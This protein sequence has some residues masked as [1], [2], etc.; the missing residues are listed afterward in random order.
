[1]QCL[2]FRLAGDE[3]ALPVL[4]V[5]E[6]LEYSG[7]TRVPKAPAAVRGVINLRGRVV[8]VVDLAPG[9]GLPPAR[10]DGRPCVVIVEA[11]AEG[12]ASVVGLLVEAVSH[13]V[14][15]GPDDVR[16]APAFGTSARLEH[17]LGI[18]RRDDRFLVL[19]DIDRA[20]SSAERAQPAV[21]TPSP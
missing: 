2:T 4:K 12:G 18:V 5:R 1:V 8:P 17:V 3:Y 16:P 11:E 20:L 19:L 13:V 9:F 15:L 14:D 6:I 10:T 21:E 7:L